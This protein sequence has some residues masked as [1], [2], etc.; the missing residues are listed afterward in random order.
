MKI[1]DIMGMG[2]HPIYEDDFER[3][4][5]AGTQSYYT[6]KSNEWLESDSTPAY[7]FRAEKAL[8]EEALRVRYV[9]GG[10]S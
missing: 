8:N 10:R 6:S 4:L 9:K 3:H 5:L 7:M 1:Y 2:T